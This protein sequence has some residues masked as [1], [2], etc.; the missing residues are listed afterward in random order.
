VE[1]ST[2]IDS[3]T[4]H[5]LLPNGFLCEMADSCKLAAGVLATI[6][7]ALRWFIAASIAIPFG[8][9]AFA[10][11]HSA[12]VAARGLL[13]GWGF[14]FAASVLLLGCAA[15]LGPLIP[16]EYCIHRN[17]ISIRN[18]S[19]QDWSRALTLAWTEITEIS[20]VR[21]A[22]RVAYLRLRTAENRRRMQVPKGIDLGE[23]TALIERLHGKSLDQR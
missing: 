10:D 23:V 17:G 20:V 18:H 19:R 6:T 4:W 7:W 2:E 13:G 9:W 11:H 8:I 16:K 5:T 3:L 12:S 21:P 15:I 14:L 22:G 1:E